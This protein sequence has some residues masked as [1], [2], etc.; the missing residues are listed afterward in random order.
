MFIELH[1]DKTWLAYS[2]AIDKVKAAKADPLFRLEH[3]VEHEFVGD[4]VDRGLAICLEKMDGLK[5]PMNARGPGSS[6]LGDDAAKVLRNPAIASK[7]PDDKQ[8]EDNLKASCHCGGVQYEIT[9]PNAESKKAW[10]P[11]PDLIV[12]AKSGHTDNSE[13][14]KWFL[15]AD[16]TKYLAGTCACRSCR[17]GSGSPIQT[18]AFIP[19]VNIVQLDG[20]PL[21]YTMGTLK[22]IENSKGNFRNF[23]SRCGANVF[24]HCLE[25]PELIDVSVGL[26]RAP[27]GARASSWLEWWTERVSFKEDSLDQGLI[28]DLEKGLRNIKNSD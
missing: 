18:W 14:V 19:K 4:T 27:E 2:G 6:K 26:L 25:R 13:D 15:R 7:H 1:D 28:G 8:P 3:V 9:R 5:V 16:D 24:W 10:S 22:Q 17:L 21:D 23:C 11:W 12:P 20:K